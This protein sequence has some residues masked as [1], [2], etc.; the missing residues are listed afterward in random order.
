MPVSPLSDRTVK[1]ISLALYRE[2]APAVEN[3]LIQ[4]HMAAPS[5]ATW[6]TFRYDAAGQRVQTPI[7]DV[8]DS[9][10][11]SYTPFPQYEE[12]FRYTW[13]GTTWQQAAA[14]TRS[15]YFL[16]GQRVATR[17]VGDPEAANNGLY[18]VL[19]D[20]LGS[21]SA[22]ATTGGAL[23]GSVVQYFPFG[24]HRA[25]STTEIT[26]RGFTG[27]AHNNLPPDGVGLIY[28]NARFYVP[29]VGRFA[30]ADTL[31]PDPARPGSFNRYSYVLQNPLSYTD[32][33]GYCPAPADDTGNVICIDL[34][35]ADSEIL[36][37]SGEGDG[38][39]FSANSLP[40][41]S[42]G[43]LYIYLDEADEN[44]NPRTE[45]WLNDSVTD[46]GVFPANFEQSDFNVTLNSETGEI[47]VVYQLRNGATAAA[48]ELDEQIMEP[49]IEC[50]EAGVYC[51]EAPAAVNGP[52]ARAVIPDINGEII[53]TPN[54]VGSYDVGVNRDPYP[55]LEI[56]QYQD[57]QHIDTLAQ[58]TPTGLGT[59]P[60]GPIT[61]LN[62]LAAN[63]AVT[64][65][66]GPWWYAR[67]YLG[68]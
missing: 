23:K 54:I 65:L 60:T 51:G 14:I 2:A 43:F 10:K 7:E 36:L 42:R 6:T 44:G 17:V 26:D 31:V 30:S 4:V 37:G 34:F 50:V 25:L 9:L 68:H 19:G 49:Y 58:L 16:D 24:K 53:L 1:L 20:Q 12:E 28:M 67:G 63:Q 62:P 56:Y 59:L 21:V 64:I 47:T 15:S 11:V 3:R 13:N 40:P 52:I 46:V 5:P 22:L 57:G 8:G 41:Q 45:F 29:A 35:I 55:W 33:T 32:P 48:Y 66:N 27:H 61:G 18:F 38:R 39:T